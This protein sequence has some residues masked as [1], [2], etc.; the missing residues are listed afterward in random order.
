MPMLRIAFGLLALT[1]TIVLPRRADARQ[2]AGSDSVAIF[3]A[4]TNEVV[5][6]LRLGRVHPR[7]VRIADSTAAAAATAVFRQ[8]AMRVD[9][10][11]AVPRCTAPL[12]TSAYSVRLRIDSI[13]GDS[14]AASYAL[15]CA[16]GIGGGSGAG[17][18]VARRGPNWVIVRM[19]DYWIS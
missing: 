6:E 1:G 8:A 15:R 4:L 3:R 17:F 19:I 12:S 13:V 11:R 10:G 2:V 5:R 16:R 18:L 14:V 9:T 7:L